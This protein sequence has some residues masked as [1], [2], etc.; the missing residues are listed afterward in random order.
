MPLEQVEPQEE[1]EQTGHLPVAVVRGSKVAAV[2]GLVGIPI[3]PPH[4]PHCAEPA[5]AD[6][7]P[8]ASATATMAASVNARAADL[9]A[10]NRLPTFFAL[11]YSPSGASSDAPSG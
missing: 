3:K 5:F 11:F 7:G 1:P 9:P 2:T 8:A 4:G 10:L 6:Q